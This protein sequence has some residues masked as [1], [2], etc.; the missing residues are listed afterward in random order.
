MPIIIHTFNIY[1]T[2]YQFSFKSS[3]SLKTGITIIY[4]IKI[5]LKIIIDLQIF[6]II[7]IELMTDIF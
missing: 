5:I 3:I 2:L 7:M 1:L 6:K 4:K